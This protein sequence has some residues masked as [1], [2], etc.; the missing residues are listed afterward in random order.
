MIGGP[1]LYLAGVILFKRSIRGHL[2]PS[3]L[4]G[5]GL[6]AILTPFAHLLTPLTLSAASTAIMLIVAIWEA[7]SLDPKH[8]RSLGK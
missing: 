2:Q 5:I 3:H 6:F 1:L 8:V 4:A 7:I